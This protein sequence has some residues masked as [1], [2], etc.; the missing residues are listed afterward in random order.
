MAVV[1]FFRSLEFSF[2]YSFRYLGVF[3]YNNNINI[4]FNSDSKTEIRLLFEISR[5][6]FQDIRKSNQIIDVLRGHTDQSWLYNSSLG[7]LSERISS[8]LIMISQVNTKFTRYCTYT[9]REN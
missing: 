3:V 4:F 5:G 1:N 8:K 6:E 2:E 7:R 9:E